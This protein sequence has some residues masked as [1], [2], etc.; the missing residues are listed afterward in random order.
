MLF[1]NF[2]TF[3]L[4]CLFT[5]VN[6]IFRSNFACVI[7]SLNLCVVTGTYDGRDNNLSLCCAGSWSCELSTIT[8]IENLYC[9]ARDSCH[10]AIISNISNT[11][12]GRGRNALNEVVVV[13]FNAML[14]TGAQNCDSNCNINNGYYLGCFG[15]YSCF[16]AN[17]SNVQFIIASGNHALRNCKITSSGNSHFGKTTMNVYLLSNGAGNE[18]NI[19]CSINDVCTIFVWNNKIY[20]DIGNLSCNS[21]SQ[22]I[23]YSL[24][25]HEILFVQFNTTEPTNIPTNIPSLDL[26]TYVVAIF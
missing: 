26:S 9:D 16:G 10:Y 6:L 1:L 24:T 4:F 11:I 15:Y 18:S 2:L 21:C 5:C 19:L 25:T 23:A 8:N 22:M 13:D 20:N 14:L 3:F 7:R 12:Q 17:I